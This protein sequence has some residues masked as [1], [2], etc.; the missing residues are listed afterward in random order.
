MQ[1]SYTW[2][3]NLDEVNGEGGT[4]LFELLL[5]TNNQLDLRHSSYGLAN[6]DRDQ[7]LVANFIWSAPDLREA[8]LIARAALNHWQLSGIGIIQSGAALSVF[9]GNAGSVYGLLSG[10]VRAQSVPGVNP[11]TK[12]SLFSRVTGNGRYLN[13]NAFTKAPEAPNGTSPA[14]QDFGDSGVG[15]VRG[16]GQQN[17]DLAL[18]RLF[19]ATETSHFVFRAEV[20]NLTNTPQFGPPNSSL[21]YGN[22]LGPA[23]AS[24]SFGS[25]S[26]EQGGPHP[27][28]LQFA[29]KYIF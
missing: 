3:K 6:D 5:P 15:I 9:D 29:A 17:L 24:S 25:I 7:R 21:G 13:A 27:R 22:P 16:P 2:S 12:G 28:I 23:T 8:P 18:E 11:S 19:P 26:S 10:E 1:A 20:F 4:D 14:D